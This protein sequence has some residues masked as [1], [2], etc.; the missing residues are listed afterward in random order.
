MFPM[1]LHRL[2]T[3]ACLGGGLAAATGCLGSGPGLAPVGGVVT[4]DGEPL[5]SGRVTFWP[6]SGRNASGWIEDDG[7]FTLGTFSD[8]DGARVGRHRVAV[9]AALRKPTAPPNFDRDPPAAGWPRSPI[10]ARYSNPDA[11]GL[12]FEVEPGSNTFVISLVSK[13]K[14][15]GPR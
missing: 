5:S 14:E 3:A 15:G 10:P 7:S 6:T 12:V 11:S 13:P 4:L 1:F 8:A 2:T 9:T